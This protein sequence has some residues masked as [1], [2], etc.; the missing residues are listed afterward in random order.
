MRTRQTTQTQSRSQSQSRSTRAT[1]LLMLL[2]AGA[3]I[4]ALAVLFPLEWVQV[5][6]I[7]INAERRAFSPN[8]DGNVDEIALIY[9]LAQDATVNVR[10]LNAGQQVIRT[11]AEDEPQAAGQHSELWDGRSDQ[12]AVVTDGEYTVRVEAKGTARSASK[13]IAVVIDN[14]PP[15]I[16]LANLPDDLKVG[17]EELLLEGTTEPGSTLWLNDQPQPVTVDANGGFSLRHRLREGENRIEL[18]AVDASGNGSSVVRDVTLVLRPP[19]IIIDNPPE[20]LWINQRLLSVQGRAASDARLLVNGKTATVSDDGSFDVDVL[21]EEGENVV[22]V[23]ATDAVGNETSVERQVFLKLQPPAISLTSITDGMEVN[24]P[25]LLVIGQTEAGTTVRVNGQELAVDTQGGFQSVV[26][27]V[28]G[29]NLVRVEAIDRAGNTAR[30]TSN[31]LYTM[32]TPQHASTTLRTALMAGAAGAA[33]V[34]ALWILLGGFYGPNALSLS[35]DQPFLSSNP[36]EGQDLRFTLELARP[37]HTTVQVWN[38]RGEW[39]ATLMSKRRRR[40]GTHTME[41]DG[42]DNTGRVVSDGAYEIE[43]TAST[44]FTTVTNRLSVFKTSE[45]APQL[46]ARRG[47]EEIEAYQRAEGQLGQSVGY[48]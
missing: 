5:P 2:A 29:P 12:G 18:T 19:E 9:G 42:L 44:I 4:V 41:W 6:S 23:E 11:L 10:V 39:V 45:R 22:R 24:E 15:L 7:T 37:A 43:V 16:R 13:N 48:E 35:T 25:S 30:A 27:L 46:W 3:I 17:E 28:E 1:S 38:G 32:A 40:A 14:T 33:L 36:F 26:N 47:A 34:F 31:V 21:L 20:G 8:G